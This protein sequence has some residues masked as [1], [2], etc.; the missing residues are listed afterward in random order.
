MLNKSLIAKTKPKADD[1]NVIFWE[2]YRITVLS[3]RLFRLEKS[4]HRKFRDCVTLSIWYRNMPPQE[5]SVTYDE[6]WCEIRSSLITFI[7][8]TRRKDCRVVINGKV[9][10]ITNDG[11]LKETYRTLDNC[12]GDLWVYEWIGSDAV[13]VNKRIKL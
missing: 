12:D 1:R 4:P 10:P 8:K 3:D 6:R 7:L 9:F 11:N 5:F 13:P 2:N